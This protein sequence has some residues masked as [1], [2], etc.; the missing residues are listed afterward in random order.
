M[1]IISS[2]SS[3]SVE[4]NFVESIFVQWYESTIEKVYI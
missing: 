4:S 3:N 2:N 1:Q